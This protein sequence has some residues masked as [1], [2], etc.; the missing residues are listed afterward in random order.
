[1]DY[2]VDF[3][4]LESEDDKLRIVNAMYKRLYGGHGVPRIYGNAIGAYVK[5]NSL[6]LSIPDTLATPEFWATIDRIKESA[7]LDGAEVL[8][9]AWR[10]HAWRMMQSQDIFGTVTTY[11]G[12][13]ALTDT[14]NT[15]T[16]LG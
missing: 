13:D 15:N 12:Y 1:M 3:S 7:C 11:Y 6:F 5:D 4:N 14:G 9:G 16:E 2:Y 10:R 8:N